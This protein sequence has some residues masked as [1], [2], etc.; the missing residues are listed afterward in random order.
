MPYDRRKVN[1]VARK[2]ARMY[3]GIV[4]DILSRE[5]SSLMEFAFLGKGSRPDQLYRFIINAVE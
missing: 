2:A 3:P 4:G 1:T 5:I